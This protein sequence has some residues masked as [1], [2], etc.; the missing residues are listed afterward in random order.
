MPRAIRRRR[1]P[2]R[3]S[4]VGVGS[5]VMNWSVSSIAFSSVRVGADDRVDGAAWEEIR[6]W[7]RSISDS[8][9]VIYIAEMVDE[10]DNSNLKKF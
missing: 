6:V 4:I 7:V 10:Y 8:C 5:A 9:F 1:H 3:D 2:R